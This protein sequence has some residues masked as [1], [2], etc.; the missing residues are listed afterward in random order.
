MLRPKSLSSL[1]NTKRSVQEH[2][3]QRVYPGKE[4]ARKGIVPPVSEEAASTST[5][6][7]AIVAQNKL[8][9]YLGILWQFLVAQLNFQVV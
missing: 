4:S 6:R 5:P 9:Q 2:W 1:E 8:C 3:L 7:W